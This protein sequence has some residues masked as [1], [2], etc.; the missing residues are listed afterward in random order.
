MQK[1]SYWRMTGVVFATVSFPS[2]D[3]CQGVVC[4]HSYTHSQ[5]E[6]WMFAHNRQQESNMQQANRSLLGRNFAFNGKWCQ[7]SP[8]LLLVRNVAFTTHSCSVAQFA[9]RGRGKQEKKFCYLI[10]VPLT[11]HTKKNEIISVL[12]W[13]WP[14][15]NLRCIF[16][17]S[18]QLAHTTCPFINFCHTLLHPVSQTHLI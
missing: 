2:Q 17:L 8:P 5:I 14:C 15:K 6:P 18:L 10:N 4:T 9:Y 3:K 12:F 1:T 7:D 16:F 13:M 11:E